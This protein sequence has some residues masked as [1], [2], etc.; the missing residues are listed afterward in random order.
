[1]PPVIEAENVIKI[2]K[3]GNLEVVALQG[4]DFT[5]ETGEFVSIVGKSGSGKSTLLTIL[6]GFDRPSAGRVTVADQDLSDASSKDLPH[7]YRRQVGFM[8][9]T[10]LATWSRI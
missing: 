3:Q 6:A 9:R 8:G 10:S 2:H 1:M 7:Y 5:M 4:L